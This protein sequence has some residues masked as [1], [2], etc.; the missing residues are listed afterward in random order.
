ML[1]LI[2][3]YN[4]EVSCQVGGLPPNLCLKNAT[5]TNG[6]TNGPDDVK[7]GQALTDAEIFWLELRYADLIFDHWYK[8][9][10]ASKTLKSRLSAAHVG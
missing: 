5:F 2:S 1:T 8:H 3:F 6:G 10:G 9:G 7:S 4:L